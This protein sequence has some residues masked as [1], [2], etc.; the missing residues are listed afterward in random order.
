M[1]RYNEIQYIL[2]HDEAIQ[3]HYFFEHGVT[4][5]DLNEFTC[6]DYSP[7]GLGD[8]ADAIIEDGEYLFRR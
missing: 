2:D 1:C 3:D 6:M 4:A 5:Y 8:I 7:D